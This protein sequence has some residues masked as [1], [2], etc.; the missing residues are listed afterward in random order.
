MMRPEVR[1]AIDA[2]EAAIER[3]AVERTSTVADLPTAMATRS[4]LRREVDDARD[5]MVAMVRGEALVDAAREGDRE[6]SK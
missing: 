2:F 4:V 6:A 5:R 1:E 3:L